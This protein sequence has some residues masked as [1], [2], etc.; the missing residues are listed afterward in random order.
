ML[1]RGRPQSAADVLRTYIYGDVALDEWK[2]GG[3]EQIG[4]VWGAFARARDFV[5]QGHIDRAVDVWLQIASMKDT[6]SRQILQAWHFLRGAGHRPPDALA[7]T[8][9]GVVIEMPVENGHDLLAAYADG[10]VRYL[11]YAGSAVVVEDRSISAIQEALQKWLEVGRL[12]VGVIGPWGQQDF[13]PLP[14]DHVRLM[15][16]TPSGPHF[17]QGP[18]EAMKADRAAGAF[19]GTGTRLMTLVASLS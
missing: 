18:L 11:N 7:K 12:I 8:V 5:Q 10:S 19:I 2:A 3:E 16:L 14:V 15:M 4:P 9:L 13:P 6:E 17:G 1:K